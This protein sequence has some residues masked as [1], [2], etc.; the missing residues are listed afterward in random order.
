M[1]FSP[2]ALYD[3]LCDDLASSP[4]IPRDV[5]THTAIFRGLGDVDYAA[6]TLN[7][8]F[9]RPEGNARDYARSAMLVSLLKKFVE[10]TDA[11]AAFMRGSKAIHKFLEV[12]E[13]CGTYRFDPTS[14]SLAGEQCHGDVK[15]FLYDALYDWSGL[16]FSWRDVL[17]HAY[18]G[19]GSSKGVNGTSE[20]DKRCT[21]V[22]C[23][24]P[25]VY[26]QW[27]DDHSS[28][29]L[30]GKTEL[31]RRLAGG[32][33]VIEDV[34]NLCCVRKTQE[35]DRTTC[36]EPSINTYYQLGL[37][38]VLEGILKRFF[39]INL[40]TQQSLNRHLARVGSV[41]GRYAT[42]DLS[43]ASDSIS[44][45]I[46]KELFGREV[47]ELLDRFRCSYTRLP[48]EFG[49]EIVELHMI[50]SMGNG[51]TFPLQ[52]MIFS[53]IVRAA[54]RICGVPYRGS[55]AKSPTFGVN[56]DD[57]I[58]DIRAYNLVIEM[59]GAYG[60]S[61]N[62][63]KTFSEGPFRESCGGD[64][65]IGH[66]VRGVYAKSLVTPQDFVSLINRLNTWSARW[67][68]PL[69][70]T[71]TYLYKCMESVPIK[72]NGKKLP[73]K[74]KVPLVPRWDGD[75]AGLK[76]PAV[77]LPTKGARTC[78]D[79]GAVMYDR[80]AARPSVTLVSEQFLPPGKGRGR[81][82]RVQ[83]RVN[84]PGLVLCSVNGTMR[85]RTY[86]TRSFVVRY[87]SRVAIAPCWE[88]WTDTQWRDL[89]IPAVSRLRWTQAVVENL[90][91]VL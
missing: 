60:F 26:Q 30:A 80:W 86:T 50:S 58:V 48:K 70:E 5:A 63:T 61:V 33:V 73:R 79:T 45:T 11:S 28:L 18:F 1:V 4:E 42:I 3:R 8:W 10:E 90:R 67:H 77:L 21:D 52:T 44:R 49:G 88:Q 55:S 39:Q 57:I 78:R 37:G 23:T 46:V 43:S 36:T 6:T 72:Q 17:H 91:E 27:L 71:I 53:A 38:G 51:Y 56:G 87:E 83:T 89:S 7:E 34:S 74:I 64:Y 24:R 62:R 68:V 25:A 32:R 76:V 59:L 84:E 85:N 82:S 69:P 40:E 75:T 12:N 41:T 65:Y 2:S 54:Y 35:I 81:P 15:Q 19:P 9:M 16:R 29:S 22:S 20:Y 47:V 14:L 31:V 13:A 66:Y